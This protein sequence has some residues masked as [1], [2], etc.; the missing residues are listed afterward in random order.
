M[1]TESQAQKILQHM[2]SGQEITALEALARFQCMR[3]AARI[4]EIKEMGIDIRDRWITR[5]DGKR[6]KAYRVQV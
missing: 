3:L 1:T 6:F 4:A 2:K 5:D